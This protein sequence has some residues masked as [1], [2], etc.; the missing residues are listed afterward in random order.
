MEQENDIVWNPL[1]TVQGAENLY[2]EIQ[3]AASV[4]PIQLAAVVY[5][6][7]VDQR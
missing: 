4:L 5:A 2:Q 3:T 7:A 1:V 6:P